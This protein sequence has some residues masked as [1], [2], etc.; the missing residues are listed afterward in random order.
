M[1][2]LFKHRKLLLNGFS[3]N[4]SV[5]VY[6]ESTDKKEFMSATKQ[7]ELDFIDGKF[8]SIIL[9]FI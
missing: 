9:A 2:L 1:L 5:R 8:I 6:C 3:R 4:R 7:I